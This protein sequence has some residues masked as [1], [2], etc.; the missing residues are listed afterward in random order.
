LFRLR[1]TMV[2]YD[3]FK[4]SLTL[5]VFSATESCEFFDT[6][7]YIGNGGKHSTRANVL[8]CQCL[9]NDFILVLT[10]KLPEIGRARVKCIC[11]YEAH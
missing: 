4:A 5:V 2:L 8:F 1:I 9:Y 3:S 7:R 11:Y 10:Q 6:L